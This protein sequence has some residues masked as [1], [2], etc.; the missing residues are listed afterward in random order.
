MSLGALA[1][2][3]SNR[4]DPEAGRH[5]LLAGIIGD[6]PSQ[7]A[8]SP[9]IWKPTFAA[10][11]IDATYL[12]FDVPADHLEKVVSALRALP[13]LAG[14]NVTVPYKIRILPFLDEIDPRA[15]RINAV[16]TVVRRP[17][18]T[19]V[20]YNTDGEGFVDSI[21][22]MP[23][24]DGQPLVSGLRGRAVLLLGA[25]GAARAIAHTLV[26]ELGEGTVVIANRSADTARALAAELNRVRA[27]AAAG[28]DESEVDAAARRAD[29]VVNATVKGQAGIRKLAGGRATCLEPYSSLAPAAPAEVPEAMAANPRRFYRAWFTASAADIEA[30]HRRSMAVVREAPAEAAFCDIVYAPLESAFLRQGRLSGRRILNGKGMNVAQA[31]SGFF[32]RVM[33]PYLKDR[34]LDIP[35]THRRIVAAMERAW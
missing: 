19:L 3:L 14:F 16:N 17:D 12:P 23:A 24:L 27:G 11:E 29:L 21:S 10:L 22:R 2:L 35:E 1:G 28:I 25:G 15:R 20:G 5:R 30:N 34:G 31:A 7:Y 9:S 8:K 4:L 32:H 13:A 26:D 33:Q 6:A 18:G